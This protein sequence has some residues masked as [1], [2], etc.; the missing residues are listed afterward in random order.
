MTS[1]R[2]LLRPAPSP[3]TAAEVARQSVM[4]AGAGAAIL[5]QVADH[6]VGAGVAAH[7]RFT[8]DPI[9]RLRHTLQYICVAVLP[10]AQFARRKVLGHVHRAHA[11]VRGLDAQGRAYSAFDPD[12]QLWVAA[13][14]H[15]AGEQVRHRVWG[16]LPADQAERMYREYASLATS[17]GVAQERWPADRTA[18]DAYWDTHMA[19]LQITPEVRD[20]AADLFSGQGLSPPLR[21]AL[22]LARLLTAGL[23]PASVR[24]GLGWA[25][26]GRDSRREARIWTV[27]APVYRR[28]PEALQSSVARW[29]L[30]T[31]RR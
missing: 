4:L 20:I 26:T 13:T 28:L 22:P 21:A 8:E 1:L 3:R 27:A 17:L 12:A 15:W 16:T 5:L 14:L 31:L 9:A 25:W 6:R 29:I 18:F 30:R 19:G 11:P 10:E 24:A 23:L 2:P 7:S